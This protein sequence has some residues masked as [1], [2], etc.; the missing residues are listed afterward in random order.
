VVIDDDGEGS[1]AAIVRLFD[2][3]HSSG[4]VFRASGTTRRE[5]DREIDRRSR[6]RRPDVHGLADGAGIAIHPD[7]EVLRAQ[8]RDVAAVRVGHDGVRRQENRGGAKG[9]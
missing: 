3:W 5:I 7:V 9:G 1:P 8:A 4:L 2:A 6:P